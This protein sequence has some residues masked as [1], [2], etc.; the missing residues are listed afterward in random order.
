MQL[1]QLCECQ[2]EQLELSSHLTE[3]QQYDGDIIGVSAYAH[4]HWQS[5][6]P[7]LF[8]KCCICNLAG[9]RAPSGGGKSKRKASPTIDVKAFAMAGEGRKLQIAAC[10]KMQLYC[11]ESLPSCTIPR[12]VFFFFLYTSLL[13]TKYHHN[14]QDSTYRFANSPSSLSLSPSLPGLKHLN[15]LPSC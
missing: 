1:S 13:L 10:G 3:S 12:L 15:S 7:L 8:R 2:L 5:P 6:P 14:D 4:L 9:S 11:F